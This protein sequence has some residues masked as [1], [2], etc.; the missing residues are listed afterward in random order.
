MPLLL[1]P[2]SIK[3][4]WK[5]STWTVEDAHELATVV[6]YVAVGQSAVVE[7]IL[8]ATDC[9]APDMPRSGAQGARG[10]LKATTSHSRVH[11]D[12][13]MFQVISW[14]AAHLETLNAHEKS[15]IRPPQMM[16]AQK[17]QDGLVIEYTDDD[18]ARVVICEDKATKSPREQFRSKVL[19]EFE[20][21]EMGERDNE[22]IASVT[23]LLSQ[24]KIDNADKIVANI[25]WEDQRA[26]RI[27]LTVP[28]GSTSD[29]D[30]KRIFKGYEQAVTGDVSRRRVELMPLS[31][32]RPWM[33]DLANEALTIIDSIDV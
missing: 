26:Y 25:L 6:A 5:G 20:S 11:R 30:Q 14:V 12:G 2:I 27:A 21:Y 29:E 18:I 33:N 8:K 24:H 19:P 9:I 13:W 23:S 10:L 22:L 15:L 28:C 31:Y 32:V 1:T 17:G 3:E 4:R 16:H 7:R